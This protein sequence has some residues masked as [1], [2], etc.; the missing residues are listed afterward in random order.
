M[1]NYTR[2]PNYRGWT[3]TNKIALFKQYE[4]FIYGSTLGLAEEPLKY[5]IHN[6]LTVVLDTKLGIATYKDPKILLKGKRG[7]KIVY[8]PNEPIIF[9]FRKVLPDIEARNKRKKQEAKEKE[10]NNQTPEDY[11]RSLKVKL[12]A[13]KAGLHR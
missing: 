5:A 11:H 13:L 9:Y 10:R 4:D 3:F 7:K 12:T 6:H 2:K 8:R 1:K